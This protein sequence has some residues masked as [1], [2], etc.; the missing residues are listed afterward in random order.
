[1]AKKIS[2]T[3]SLPVSTKESQPP[4]TSRKYKGQI[5]VD[6]DLFRL[7]ISNTKKNISF[8][9][10]EYI[11][12]EI[13]H[14]HMFHTVDSDGKPQYKTCPTASHFHKMT[15]S[16]IDGELVAKCSVPYQMKMVKGQ[17]VEVPYESDNH[18]HEVTYL[19]SERIMQRVYNKDA[20]NMINS[21]KNSESQKLKNP[22]I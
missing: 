13:P 21:I 1:M 5:E 3:Q 4:K 22:T 2:D 20:L 10:N 16:E 12:E 8:R 9:K 19:R 14:K 7:E 11:W 18:K 17:R 6:H 15:V